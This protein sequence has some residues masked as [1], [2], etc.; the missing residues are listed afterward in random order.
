MRHGGCCR[1]CFVSFCYWQ[2]PT[3]RT[4]ASS[5]IDNERTD[6]YAYHCLGPA[7]TAKMYA[8]PPSSG[9][10]SSVY[11]TLQCPMMPTSLVLGRGAVVG[12]R[13]VGWGVPI[14]PWPP[15]SPVGAWFR[16]NYGY[17]SITPHGPGQKTPNCWIFNSLSGAATIPPL[18]WAISSVDALQ[19]VGT[20]KNQFGAHEI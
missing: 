3:C 4:S 2:Q 15:I 19:R 18:F 1:R 12:R 6:L 10:T 16:V 13:C 14:Q 7:K 17:P 20:W 8:L 9:D 11:G 5:R